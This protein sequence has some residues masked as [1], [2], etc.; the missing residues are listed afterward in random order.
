M[1]VIYPVQLDWEDDDKELENEKREIAEKMNSICY[2]FALGIPGTGKN[3]ISYKYRVN[4]IKY[5]EML[6]ADDDYEEETGEEND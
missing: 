3:S 6:G 1:L 5:R 2:G 4:L